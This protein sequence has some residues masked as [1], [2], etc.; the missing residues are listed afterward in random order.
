VTDFGKGFDPPPGVRRVVV[1]GAPT[2]VLHEQLTQELRGRTP[3]RFADREAVMSWLERWDRESLRQ[4]VARGLM[5]RVGG[6]EV[7]GLPEAPAV[8]RWKKV[9]VF[10]A[11]V[12]AWQIYGLATRRPTRAGLELDT[13]LLE[14]LARA[15]RREARAWLAEDR[16]GDQR[17]IEV[18]TP[19]ESRRIVEDLYRLGAADVRVTPVLAAPGQGQV[20][21]GLAVKLPDDAPRRGALFAYRAQVCRDE[22][23]SDVGQQHLFLRSFKLSRH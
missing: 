5:V 15:P 22:A 14:R 19:E 1:D 8:S 13:F 6:H 17:R 18:Q 2:E 12:M 3:D 20:A 16:P 10:L 11:A 4:Q 23:R 21:R 9:P 7:A